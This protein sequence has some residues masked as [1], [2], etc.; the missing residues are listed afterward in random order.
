MNSCP[1]CGYDGLNAPPF[2]EEG[3]PSYDICNCCGYEFGFDEENFDEYRLKW[4]T[5]GTKW[6]NPKVQPKDWIA[7]EQLLKIGVRLDIPDA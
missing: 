4:L 3:N 6:F 7:S 2:D 5:S 1:V